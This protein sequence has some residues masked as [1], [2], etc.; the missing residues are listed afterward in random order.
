[1]KIFGFSTTTFYT[2]LTIGVHGTCIDKRGYDIFS[3][4]AF[5][6]YRKKI[7]ADPRLAKY[8]LRLVIKEYEPDKNGIFRIVSTTY[9]DY[10]FED[11]NIVL[12]EEQHFDK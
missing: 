8:Y 6:I 4:E 2:G 11:G 12:M 3:K 5:G 1:M 9:R 10:G 7:E